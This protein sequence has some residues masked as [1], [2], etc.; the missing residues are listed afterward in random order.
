MV[1]NSAMQVWLLR[2]NALAF[3]VLVSDALLRNYILVCPFQKSI[4]TTMLLSAN[5]LIYMGSC[6]RAV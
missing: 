5:K 3:I 2:R 1:G 6:V 4:H